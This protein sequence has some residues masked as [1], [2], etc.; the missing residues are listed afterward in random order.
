MPVS[1]SYPGVYVEEV[2][3]GVRT[4]VGV[5]TS[6]AAFIGR[7][8]KG[9][10]NIATTIN[11]FG[12]FE[13]IFGGLWSDSSMSF[14]VRDFFLNGGGQ[15]V[16]VRLFHR[17]E[18]TPAATISVGV[19]SLPKLEDVRKITIGEW[20]FAA[21]SPGKWGASLRVKISQAEGPGAAAV[22]KQMGL[23]VSD[24]YNV[25]VRDSTP[26][27]GAEQFLNVSVKPGPR[28]LD[29]VLAAESKLLF[30]DGRIDAPPKSPLTDPKV[31]AF[32]DVWKL[33]LALVDAI[34]KNGAGSKEAK[35][36]AEKVDKKVKGVIDGLTDGGGLVADD[37][38]PNNA[39][40]NKLGLFALERLY[41]TGG[42]FNLLCIPPYTADS[43]VEPSVINIAA[44]YCETRR[45]MLLIDAPT[46]WTDTAKAR[47]NFATQVNF[48][49][50][51][52]NAAVYFPRL[53]Q[54]NPLRDGQIED[55]AACGVI[56][57]IYARTDTQRGVWKAP[58]GMD[59]SLVG[60]TAL[61]VPMTD[62][63][64]GPLNQL[65]INCLRNFPVIGNVVWG[66]RTLR[67]ADQFS[68]EYKY[69]PVRRTA[70]FIE[71]SLYR[72][73][74]WVVFEPNDEP[75]WAQIRLN[76]GAF[77]HNLFRQG[78]FQG[79][80]PRDAYFVKCSKET[81]SE[82]DRIL[83]IVNVAVGFAPLKPAEFVVIKF[84]QMAGQV[85]T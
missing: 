42:L 13:R 85:D 62:D 24:L 28:Q 63:D 17:D 6:V 38:T 43:N 8:K 59:A 71:E 72:G 16:I 60:V 29:K 78:A 56:A 46:S 32:D 26:G 73:L 12:E 66:G 82:D 15:A 53:R 5:S 9:P 20:K 68:D 4:V 39:Q 65:G 77:M 19:D 64:N 7:A 1:L 51:S 22:A 3:S 45:A 50:T 33:E 14:A 35:D 37:F 76:A 18:A 11:G 67:G 49:T 58:A 83:G 69:I 31:P 84:Q 44:A 21:A 41:A 81:T 74:K 54:A 23:D 2:S 55:F 80:S 30:W 34:A 40:A 57:G 47:E 25:T 48:Q 52:R 36:A 70:L 61:T 75:L 79:S 27:A 10:E